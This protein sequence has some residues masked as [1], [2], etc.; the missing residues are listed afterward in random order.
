M[1]WEE[2]SCQNHG[3]SLTMQR[4]KSKT[5]P[6]SRPAQKTKKPITPKKDE[7]KGKPTTRSATAQQQEKPTKEQKQK[8]D[9]E[10]EEEMLLQALELSRSGTGTL[11]L[12]TSSHEPT[13]IWNELEE[14]QLREALNRSVRETHISQEG[15]SEKMISSADGVMYSKKDMAT[16]CQILIDFN[17]DPEA[18]LALHRALELLRQERRKVQQRRRPQRGRRKKEEE[19]GVQ[20]G[21]EGQRQRQGRWGL[22]HQRKITKSAAA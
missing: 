12:K 15:L 17:Q 14:M 19:G 5:A 6:G 9:V 21:H 11:S 20:E 18:V 2:H 10:L 1:P 13:S 3:W 16:V 22:Y 8:T 4:I 7:F